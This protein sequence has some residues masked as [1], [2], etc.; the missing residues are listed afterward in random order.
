MSFARKARRQ[1][2]KELTRYRKRLRAI[3]RKAEEAR[4]NPQTWWNGEPAEARIVHVVVGEPEKPT[5]WF[6]DLVG[7]VREAVEVTYGGQT[8]YIDNQGFESGFTPGNGWRKVTMGRG[9]P[10]FGH[11]SLRIERVLE[12]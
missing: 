5:W 12:S 10:D 11:A 9:A 4:A 2:E 6:A 1:T 8:F 3:D 7:T